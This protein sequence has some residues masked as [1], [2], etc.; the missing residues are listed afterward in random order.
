M[1]A[2]IIVISELLL[3]LLDCR[4]SQHDSMKEP[5]ETNKA[6]NRN[7]DPEDM[8]IMWERV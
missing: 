7:G 8:R 5:P 1:D 6:G 2:T 3:C 4:W